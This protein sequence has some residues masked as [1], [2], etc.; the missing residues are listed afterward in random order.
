M[1]RAVKEIKDLV[2]DEVSLVDKGANQHAAVTIA[3]S[4]TGQEEQ[5]EIEIFDE[6]GNPLDP[7]SLEDGQVVYG[8]DGTAYVYEV[9][10]EEPEEQEEEQ[11]EQPRELAAV[12]KAFRREPVQKSS[13]LVDSFREELSKALSDKDRDEVIAKA[14]GAVEQYADQAHRAQEIAKAERDLRLERE[15]TEVAKS[16]NLPVPAESLGKVMKKM[17]ET[18]TEAE[19]AVVAKCFE[20][21]SESIFEE[22]GFAG[23]GSNSDVLQVASAAID[24]QVSKGEDWS[25]EAAMASFFDTNPSAYDE[26]LSER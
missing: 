3:K 11:Q 1:G 17:A 20:A 12:G 7:E 9:D 25:K 21:A 4:A 10:G 13:S 23:G 15:Y 2:I 8:E 22:Q 19:C 5:M 16:Y 18:L 24:S 26:Y 14:L 6:S